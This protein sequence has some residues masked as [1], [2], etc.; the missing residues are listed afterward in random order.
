MVN[1]VSVQIIEAMPFNDD[2]LG[3]LKVTDAIEAVVSING[4]DSINVV[5][6]TIEGIMIY[7]LELIGFEDP[8]YDHFCNCQENESDML[9]RMYIGA[10]KPKLVNLTTNK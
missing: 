6:G 2:S 1:G 7:E 3:F 10:R 5:G 4:V 8:Y 9:Y